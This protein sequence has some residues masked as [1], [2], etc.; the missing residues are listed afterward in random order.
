VKTVEL[1]NGVIF[2]SSWAVAIKGRRTKQ[3]DRRCIMANESAGKRMRY[4]RT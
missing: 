3:R 1:T 2:S 4:L